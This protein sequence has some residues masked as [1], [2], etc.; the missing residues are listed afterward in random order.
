MIEAGRCCRRRVVIA[1]SSISV[2]NR[3]FSVTWIV[4]SF[5]FMRVMVSLL[6]LVFGLRAKPLTIVRIFAEFS[7]RYFPE[8][9]VFCA[10]I[11][12]RPH[13]QE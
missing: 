2:R 8:L 13:S 3:S 7:G 6:L 1:S 5:R 12:I 10:S 9:D 4:S 11:A